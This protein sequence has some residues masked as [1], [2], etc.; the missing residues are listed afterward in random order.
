MQ[1]R[2]TRTGTKKANEVINN[3]KK[4]KRKKG[5]GEGKSK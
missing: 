1:K 3:Q 5:G 2:E 4:Q